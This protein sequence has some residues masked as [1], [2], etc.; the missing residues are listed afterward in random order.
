VMDADSPIIRRKVML[1]CASMRWAVEVGSMVDWRT[2]GAYDER[3]VVVVEEKRE[4]PN[5]RRVS[6][7]A[8]GCAGS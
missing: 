4:I 3:W 7:S 2:R 8:T 1:S 5:R 6:C